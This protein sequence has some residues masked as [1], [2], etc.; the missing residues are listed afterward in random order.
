MRYFKHAFGAA[1][2]IVALTALAW[3]ILD[4]R[5][6]LPVQAAE[7]AKPIDWLFNLQFKLMAVMFGLIAGL[8]LYSVIFFRRKRGD[9]SDGPHITGN[10]PL[11]I[12]WTA[13]PLAIVTGLA[14]IGAQNLSE[15]QRIDPRALE[16]KVTAMQ[17]AWKFEYPAYEIVSDQLILPANQQIVFKLNSIDVIHSF[18]VPEWRVKQDAVPGIEQIL[19]VTPSQA[20][21]FKLVCAEICGAQH[22]NMVATVKVVSEDE[23]KGWVAQQLTGAVAEDPAVRGEQ[24]LRVNG[25]IACH[26][27]DGTRLVGPT[28]QGAYG[29]QETL[30]DGSTIT[31]DDAYILESIRQSTKKIVQGYPGVMPSY[32]EDV[33]SDS[34]VADIIEYIKTLK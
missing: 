32:G 33:I 23:F 27:I 30:E 20:G 11:E 2:F 16:V 31:V 13:I 29:R 24:V 26:S 9:T 15:T 25:C 22:A 6:L 17:W 21:E 18:W 12:I 8:M 4:T 7:Q 34:Q 28:F 3:F 10:T 14:L 5:F 19:R 1:M